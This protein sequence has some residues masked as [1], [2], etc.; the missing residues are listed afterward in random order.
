MISAV[1]TNVLL[2]ILVPNANHVEGSRALV[3]EARRLGAVVISEAAYAELAAH[4][5]DS[6]GF[7]RF[8]SG[9]GIRL[10]RS[11][12]AAL[13]LAGSAWRTYT[14]RRP[15]SL[16]CAQCGT[17]QSVRCEGCGEPL[18]TR[19][20]IVADFLIGAHALVHA[21]RLLTRDRGFYATY[22]PNLELA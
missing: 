9:I 15:R 16:V 20:H 21:D 4:F 5:Q 6:N 12:L 13:D 10:E 1:D 2:D 14:R 7:E 19:Q 17:P 8:R 22:F 18:R 3:A 11:S